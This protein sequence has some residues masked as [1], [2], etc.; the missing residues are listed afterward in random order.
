MYEFDVS[1]KLFSNNTI[2]LYKPKVIQF[3]TLDEL[4][5]SATKWISTKSLDITG[6]YGTVKLG[7]SYTPTLGSVYNLLGKSKSMPFEDTEIYQTEEVVE[8]KRQGLITRYLTQNS[9][10][11]CRSTSFVNQKL[12][13]ENQISNYTDI[14]D[15]FEDE[16]S[17]DICV[18]EI[19]N[20]G[21]FAGIRANS[22]G[23]KGNAPLVFADNSFCAAVSVSTILNSRKIMCIMR[24]ENEL[25]D[26]IISGNKTV[27]ELPAKALLSHPNLT[28][29]YFSEI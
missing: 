9:L 28:I 14:I 15:Q 18:L 4:Y 29:F 7:L 5:R 10:D 21:R 1:P 3:E 2:S 8:G 16:E 24:D 11:L 23:L 22:E 13:G 6:D 19:D 12:E 25:I 26:D 27:L 17:F 20:K